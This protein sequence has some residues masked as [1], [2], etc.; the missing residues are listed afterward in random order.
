M[1][2]IVQPDQ[3]NVRKRNLRTIG[4]E[5]A[6]LIASALILSMAFPGFISKNGIGF[7]ALIALIPVFAVIRNAPI[8]ACMGYGFFFGFIFY[9]F[10]NYW[11]ATFHALAIILVPFIKAV[12]M[13]LLFLAL[14]LCD[15]WLG[16]KSYIAQAVCWVAYAYLSQSWFAGYP[17]GSIAYA[18]Y[19]YRALIQIADFSG[20]WGITFLMVLPQAFAGKWLCD[21]YNSHFKVSIVPSL[22]KEAIP[23]GIYCLLAVAS[24]IYGIVSISFWNSQ[25][26]DITWKVAAVQHNADSWKGGY[27]TYKRNFNNLRKMT[28]E[29]L[30]EDPDM[31]IWSETAFVPS[32]AWH[33]NYPNA[34][35]YYDTAGLVEEFVEFGKGLPVPLLTG[36]PEGVLDGDEPY[37]ADGSWNRKDY[38]T[39]IFF[40]D[41]QIK[42][43]YRKQHLVP[44]T[45][46]FPY[47]RQMPWLYNLLLANDYNWWEKGTESV[48][49]ETEQGVKFSTPICFEDVFGD[50]NAAFVK[51]GADLILNM[52]NDSWSGS[53]AAEMQHAA[54][55][56][57]RSVENRKTMVR[58]TNSGISCMI[59]P[60]GK[61][62]DKME[63]FKMYWHIYDVPVYTSNPHTFYTEH[64]DLAAY[65]FV[66]ASYALL[67]FG[68]VKTLYIFFAKNNGAD[69]I[70]ARF[71]RKK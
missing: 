24:V 33:T 11:L 6:V 47:E 64:G 35:D 68:L 18:L 25:T 44:F 8:G 4:L 28:Y 43:T 1:K 62:E 50:I 5:V 31:V 61:I 32:V 36:N 67:A 65:I 30:L 63:P 52:T 3:I 15:R 9:L 45:E 54:I 10:F 29:A 14:K 58:A 17:Y 71:R 48:V 66:W 2:V 53:T 22:R 57:F 70:K 42:Q 27:T 40:E 69:R 23:L 59:T 49:F 26:P 38:N 46:H 34:D 56:A 7:L 60:T 16:S 41:G 39:V 51:N 55:A 37:N 21:S 20:I 12:E 19:R 13:L